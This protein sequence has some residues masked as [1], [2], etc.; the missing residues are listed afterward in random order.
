MSY[1]YF[2]L[3]RMPRTVRLPEPA[4]RSGPDVTAMRNA[5][6][7]AAMKQVLA[8]GSQSDV[9]RLAAQCDREVVRGVNICPPADYKPDNNDGYC[10]RCEGFAECSAR[11]LRMNRRAPVADTTIVP[12]PTA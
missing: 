9:D 6:R 3:Q 4:T 12:E 10:I 11:Y 5:T 2:L 1:A 8:S 7:F